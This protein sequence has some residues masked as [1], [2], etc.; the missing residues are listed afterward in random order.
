M[1]A[2]HPRRRGIITRSQKRV[3][4]AKVE[5]DGSTSV[6]GSKETSNLFTVEL[7]NV[8][9]RDQAANLLLTHRQLG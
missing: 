1:A 5:P 2:F 6:G 9:R 3:V 4:A 8:E 7:P